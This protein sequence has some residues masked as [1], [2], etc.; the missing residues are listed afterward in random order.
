MRAFDFLTKNKYKNSLLTE[1]S[2]KFSYI[3][4][5]QVLTIVVDSQYFR[6]FL[7]LYYGALWGTATKDIKSY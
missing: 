6:Y 3:R 5:T 1:F 7:T 4:Y 2:S